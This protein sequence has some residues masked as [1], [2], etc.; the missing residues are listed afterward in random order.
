MFIEHQRQSTQ[1]FQKI[2]L[3]KVKPVQNNENHQPQFYRFQLPYQVR[4][5][6][7]KPNRISISVYQKN[8]G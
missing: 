2:V 5:H 6:Y 7:G 4:K 1:V 8:H 3:H